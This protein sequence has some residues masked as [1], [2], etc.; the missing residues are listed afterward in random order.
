MVGRG[1]LMVLTEAYSRSLAERVRMNRKILENKYWF[2]PVDDKGHEDFQPIGRGRKSS[3]WCG[4]FRGL[5]VCKNVEGHKGIVLSGVDCS[6]KVVVR[7]QHFWCKNSSCP[8]C[9][10]CGWSVR[11]AKFIEGRLNVGVERGF[12]KVEHVVVSVSEADYNLAESVLR[13]K[14]SGRFAGLR[15]CWWCINFSRFSY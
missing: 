14:M 10:I 1:D 13:K 4:K 15:C 8:V 5:V 12:G 7:H 9:F 6:G 3:D 2:L 11:G